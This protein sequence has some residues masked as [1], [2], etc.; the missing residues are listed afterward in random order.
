MIQDFLGDSFSVI[1]RADL[2][3][4]HI[5]QCDPSHCANPCWEIHKLNNLRLFVLLKKKR[6]VKLSWNVQSKR[7]DRKDLVLVQSQ[8]TGN[9]K[10]AFFRFFPLTLVRRWWPHL[11]SSRSLGWGRSLAYSRERGGA[12]WLRFWRRSWR[13]TCSASTQHRGFSVVVFF[14]FVTLRANHFPFPQG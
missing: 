2:P 12:S 5:L 3:A 11:G 6:G 14:F 10:S 8:V 4:V 1:S 7:G 9:K 13:T